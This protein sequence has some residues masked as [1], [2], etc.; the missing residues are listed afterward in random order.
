MRILLTVPL[1]ALG[2]AAGA[3]SRPAGILVLTGAALLVVIVR[4]AR[5]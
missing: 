2:A 3:F 1:L 5:A 4:E